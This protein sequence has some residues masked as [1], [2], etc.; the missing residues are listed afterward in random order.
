M[1]D[2]LEAI[3]LRLVELVDSAVVCSVDEC[4]NIAHWL[5][6]CHKCPFTIFHCDAC[7]GEALAMLAKGNILV[8]GDCHAATGRHPLTGRFMKNFHWEPI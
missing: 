2:V 5:V 1:S 7:R 6:L 4:E 3:D 8:C